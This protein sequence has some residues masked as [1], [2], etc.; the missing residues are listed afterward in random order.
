[1]P[2]VPACRL[3][4]IG[5]SINRK[6]PPTGTA[7]LA[8]VLVSGHSRLPWPPPRTAGT[9]SR[10]PPSRVIDGDAIA[11]LCGRGRAPPAHRSCDDRTAIE[12]APPY[13]RRPV[14]P[15]VAGAHRG[16]LR[17][18]RRSSAGRALRPHL[19]GAHRAAVARDPPARLP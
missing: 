7:G 8:R 9:A 4:L 14:R 12:S 6:R 18:R 13:A 2:S 10:A 16:P 17:P 15:A 5:T 1:M 3:L 19:A 11:K